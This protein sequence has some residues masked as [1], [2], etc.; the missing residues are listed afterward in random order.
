MKC[1]RKEN[2]YIKYITFKNAFLSKKENSTQKLLKKK[3]C[4]K[5][6]LK[7]ILKEDKSENKKIKIK[8]IV[9]INIFSKNI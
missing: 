7:L 3:N 4:S 2:T 6:I 5:F 8:V 1:K 9:E